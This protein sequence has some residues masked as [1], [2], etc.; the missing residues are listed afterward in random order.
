[1]RTL[2]DTL[3]KHGHKPEVRQTSLALLERGLA[4]IR[5]VVRS[6][7]AT[8]KSDRTAAQLTHGDL[9]DLRYLVQHEVARRRLRLDFD[10][11]LP[12][13]AAVD[14]GAVRQATLNLLLNAC[15]ASPVGATVGLSAAQRGERLEIAVSDQGPGLPAPQAELLVDSSRL[16]GAPPRGSGLGLWM[17]GRLLR[18]LDGSIAVDSAIQGGSVITMTIPLRAAVAD[19]DHVA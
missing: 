6:T 17:V 14:G 3:A 15:A 2:V 4:G 16:P 12:A 13:L 11:R 5:E 9:E 19:L 8:Y 1:M 18:E 10:N 7:L